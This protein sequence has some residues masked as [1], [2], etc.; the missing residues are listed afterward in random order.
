[1]FRP[2]CGFRQKLAYIVLKSILYSSWLLGIF[3]FKYDSKQR[4]LRRSKWL[5]LFGIAMSSCP[6]ILMLKQSAEDQKHAIRLDVFQRNSLLHQ[7]SSLMGVVG[8]VTICTVYLRTLWR[9]K[10]L[11]EIYNGLMLLEA[12]YFCSDAVDCPAFDGYVVQ[13]G[14]LIIVGL[15]APWMVHFGMSNINLHV[16]SVVVVSVIKL[17]TLLLAV[18]YHLGVA[19]IYRFVWLINR[20]LLSLVSSLRG[21]HKGSSSRVR[22]LLKLYTQLVHLYSRLADCYDCQTVLMM[23][24]FLAANIIVCFYMIVYRIS[25]S[26]MSFFV[27]LIMFPLALAINFMDFWLIM[28]LCDLLQKTGRQTSMILKL[29][30][31]IE[32]MDKDLERSISDFALYC[33]HQ[34]FKFLHCGLFYV[35]REMGFEMFVAS[36]LYLL[37]LV[38]FDFMNL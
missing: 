33:S 15:L 16:M 17:G 34:R 21:N 29:F 10:H 18:H 36:V 2:R 7:I 37:Y 23:T 31:D 19:F 26:R 28:Q 9:S 24:V 27:M 8:V 5:I 4:R 22:F 38:Q 1:M 13:K 12:K 35:N 11:E 32:S 14:V 6:L 25:L 30:N 3:P 20:E